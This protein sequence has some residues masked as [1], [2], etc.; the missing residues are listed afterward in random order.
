VWNEEHMKTSGIIL[1][2]IT[3][4]LFLQGCDPL[5]V[6]EISVKSKERY[7]CDVDARMPEI[8]KVIESAAVQHGFT[9]GDSN[10]RENIRLAMC[11]KASVGPNWLTVYSE[12]NAMKFVICEFGH[13]KLSDN[14]RRLHDAIFQQLN[15]SLPD[16]CV[17]TKK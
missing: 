7:C 6:G 14:S 8:V 3:A 16:C 4:G 13:V 1:L 15:Q 12:P 2:C 5:A 10:E 17:V 9:K 11:N